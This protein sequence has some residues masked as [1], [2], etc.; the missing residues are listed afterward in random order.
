MCFPI[1]C[2]FSIKRTLDSVSAN[3]GHEKAACFRI[4]RVKEIRFL[5]MFSEGS[6]KYSLPFLV[7]NRISSLRFIIA[8]LQSKL[9]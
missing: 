9:K 2:F 6:F 3:H 1:R 7:S 4:R 5:A 8:F